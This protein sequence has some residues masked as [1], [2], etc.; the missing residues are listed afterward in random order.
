M[1][2]NNEWFWGGILFHVVGVILVVVIKYNFNLS[3]EYFIIL[4]LMLNVVS[5][6]LIDTI[7]G[8]GD[9]K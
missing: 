5:V 8:M 3:M 6:M 9:K 1:T 7:L 4:L 2:V